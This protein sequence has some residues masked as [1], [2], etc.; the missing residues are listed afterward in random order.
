MKKKLLLYSPTKAVVVNSES[1]GEAVALIPQSKAADLSLETFF[2]VLHC[3]NSCFASFLFVVCLCLLNVQ[4]FHVFALQA[5]VVWADCES[6]DKYSFTCPHR[7]WH[8][9]RSPL[10][11]DPLHEGCPSGCICVFGRW[12]YLMEVFFFFIYC[13]LADW[14]SVGTFIYEKLK[15]K[16]NFV[17]E[18]C[19]FSHH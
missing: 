17:S 18:V 5:A 3:S 13:T 9:V 1:L 4:A 12:K 14:E 11:W 19:F 2:T 10:C 16:L 8:A 7:S 15:F 6:I